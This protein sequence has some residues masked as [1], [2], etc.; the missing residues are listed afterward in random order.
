MK[1]VLKNHETEKSWYWLMIN[2]EPIILMD[3]K[4]TT[5]QRHILSKLGIQY[6]V[7]H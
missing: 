3:N 5:Q 2:D 7:E 4:E 6:S 1:V